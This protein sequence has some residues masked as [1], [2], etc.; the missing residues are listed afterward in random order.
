MPGDVGCR[1]A[2][3]GPFGRGGNVDWSD[4]EISANGPITAIE[5]AIEGTIN[6]IRVRY[7]NTWGDWHPAAAGSDNTHQYQTLNLA[8]G[9]HIEKVQGRSGLATD[10]ISFF[11]SDGQVHGPYG[12]SGGWEDW[13]SGGTPGC[14][15]SFFSGKDGQ[16]GGMDL[17]KSLNI[18]YRCG[19]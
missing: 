3:D 16:Y 1:I 10:K 2:V 8:A 4:E 9:A 13:T 18:H 17:I 15:V 19:H 12:G 14:A 5:M 6:G 7:G 11:S